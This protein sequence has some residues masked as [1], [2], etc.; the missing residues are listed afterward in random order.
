MMKRYTIYKTDK[1]TEEVTLK[2]TASLEK[3]QEWVGGNIEMAFQGKRRTCWVN[4]EG[5]LLKLPPNPFFAGIVGNVVVE[6]KV[7]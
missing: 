2:R 5:L 7:A 4:E 6:E 1:T 3:L